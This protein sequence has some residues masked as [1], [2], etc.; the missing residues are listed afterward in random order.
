M[1]LTQMMEILNSDNSD[2][3]GRIYEYFHIS[4]ETIRDIKKK[5]ILYKNR[6]ITTL[7]V[8]NCK[9]ITNTRD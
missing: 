5:S 6:K 9:L 1:I 2:K 8:G 3:N 7:M 4:P